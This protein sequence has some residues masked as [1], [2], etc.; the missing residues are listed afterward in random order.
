MLN[1]KQHQWKKAADE[2]I[3]SVHYEL[4]RRR[5]TDALAFTAESSTGTDINFLQGENLNKNLTYWL[6]DAVVRAFLAGKHL[7]ALYD[8]ANFSEYFDALALAEQAN[9]TKSYYFEILEYP[10]VMGYPISNEAPFSDMK[11]IRHLRS[12]IGEAILRVAA[13]ERRMAA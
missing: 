4:E 12:D 5:L 13:M 9:W 2:A 11:R 6:K 1:K 10:E 8:G 7:D 3:S